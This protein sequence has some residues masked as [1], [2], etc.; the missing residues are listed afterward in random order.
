[1]S[2][3]MVVK[4]GD[5]YKA[6]EQQQINSLSIINSLLRSGYTMVKVLD[7]EN[8]SDAIKKGQDAVNSTYEKTKP[9]DSV[10]ISISTST[11]KVPFWRR[12]LK[13]REVLLICLAVYGLTRIGAD[14]KDQQPIKTE[15]KIT[16][17]APVNENK[18][19]H[20][21]TFE[22]LKDV[23]AS[24]IN[25]NGLLC[26]EVIDTRPLKVRED[27]YEVTCIEYRGGSGKKTYIM[28]IANGTAWA[29]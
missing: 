22:D 13:T 14:N 19:K 23:T 26:A 3:Y 4:K 8:A 6:V 25:L 24:I 15:S 2:I 27:I 16:Q 29:Q 11:N 21:P 1:M 20:E 28:D 9:I 18:T 7:A 5:T 10:K 12:E 17:Q